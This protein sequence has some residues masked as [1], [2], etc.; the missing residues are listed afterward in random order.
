MNPD[1]YTVS[2][3][4]FV[5]SIA[6]NLYGACKLRVFVH[7]NFHGTYSTVHQKHL[8]NVIPCVQNSSKIVHCMYAINPDV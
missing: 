1:V 8:P 2:S 3:Q 6:T 5:S 7:R 4:D